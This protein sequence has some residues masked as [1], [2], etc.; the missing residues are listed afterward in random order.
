MIS[1]HGD[2]MRHDVHQHCL[3]V[4]AGL[5]PALAE[6]IAGVGPL[7]W[8]ARDDV[9]LAAYLCRVVAGQQLSVT[10]AR[11]IWTRVTDAVG[12]TPLLAFLEGGR[13]ERLRACGLSAA[14]VQTLLAIAAEARVGDLDAVVLRGL[15]PVS[16]RERLTALRGVGPWTADMVEIFYFGEPDVWPE[17]DLAARQTLVRLT[18]PRRKTVRTA[19]RFAPLLPGPLPV[20]AP[21][22][23][24]AL[25]VPERRHPR[26]APRRGCRAVADPRAGSAG[27][28]MLRE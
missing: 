28:S 23:R 16:R 5:S 4:A 6:A 11:A 14:K 25:C 9:P 13:A 17:G 1:P 12:E 22:R 18:S 3:D 26:R 20:A 15:D 8:P 10:A 21:G 27:Q 7:S 19:A 2:A 24:P